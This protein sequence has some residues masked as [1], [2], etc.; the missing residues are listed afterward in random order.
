MSITK[1][2][3]TWMTKIKQ[4]IPNERITRVQNLAWLVTGIY[5]S[6]S[7]HLSKVASKIPG[8]ALLVSATRRLDRFLENKEFRVR[9]WYEPIAKKLVEQRVGQEYRLIV[10]G[11]KVGFGHQFLVITLAYRR[12]AIPLVWMWVRCGRGHSTSGRQ[13]ALLS[14][15]HRLLAED[16]QV[17]LLG[18]SE[19]GAIEVLKQLDKWGWKYVLRQKGSHLVR[20][21]EQNPW[22]SLRSC[23]AKAGESIWLGQRQLTQLHA[24]SVN[25]LA[26]WKIGEKE[27]WLLATNLPSLREALRAYERRMWIEEMFG[28]LKSNGF[29][30]ESTHLRSVFKLHRLT[31]AVVLLFL[32][33]LTSGSKIVKNGLRY[34]VDRADRRDLSLFRIGLY[35]RERH[36][37]NST[38]FVLDFFPLL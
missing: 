5:A 25:V 3:H 10:D 34:L 23:I 8:E 4:L 22:I 28:D 35:M 9:E 19:F 7:V 33:L 15:I 29:D 2:Y 30:L 14:Y 16:A 1:L 21:N 31:F 24:Y 13:L 38:S 27:P 17:L 20:E 12:R 36:L 18:D 11:S 37:A 6:K 26:H 32:E